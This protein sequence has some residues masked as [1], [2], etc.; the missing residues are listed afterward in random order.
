MTWP[1]ASRNCHRNHHSHWLVCSIIAHRPCPPL[2]LQ[3]AG[4]DRRQL[5]PPHPDQ[6]T[7]GQAQP[8]CT[9][10]SAA[11]RPGHTVDSLVGTS[12]PP[13]QR[14]SEHRR[15]STFARHSS[16]A[17][18]NRA[19]RLGAA[20]PPHPAPSPARRAPPEITPACSP[21]S[22]PSSPP[23]APSQVSC[24][25]LPFPPWRQSVLPRWHGTW[26]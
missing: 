1:G 21:S 10:I 12:S 3:S 14:R 20:I 8:A 16:R 6:H 9:A 19:W 13:I 25:T 22:R 5:H 26:R 17:P 11:A 2:P 4:D 15:A 24:W 23:H 18:R 7:A